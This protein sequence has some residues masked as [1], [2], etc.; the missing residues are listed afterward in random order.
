MHLPDAVK[1]IAL[2][3]TKKWDVKLYIV[4]FNKLIMIFGDNSVA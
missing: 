4:K 2:K 3:K 1:L